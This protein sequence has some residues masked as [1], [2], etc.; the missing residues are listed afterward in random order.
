MNAL[1]ARLAR[2]YPKSN[3]DWGAKLV[4]LHEQMVGNI[5]P[6]LL[7]LLGA[8]GFVL[9]MA[10]ANIANLLLARAGAREKEIAIRLALGARR[11]RLIRQFLT[12]SILLSVLGGSAGMLLAVLGGELLVAI[13][14]VSIPR[15]SEMGPDLRL[16]GFTLAVVFLTGIIFGLIPALQA[17][18][19]DLNKVLKE[20]GR[21]SRASASGDRIRSVLVVSEI[22]IALVLLVGAGLLLKT[23]IRLQ[24]VNPGFN[25]TN[26]L[27]FNLQLPST[28]Y[29]DWLQ[30]SSFYSQLLERIK[31]LPGVQSADVA[32]FLPLESGWRM[33]FTITGQPK[34]ADGEDLMA[35]YRMVSPTYFQTMG[36]PLLQGRELTE[37]EDADAPGVVVINQAM[38]ARYWPGEDP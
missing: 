10:C 3:T 8:V 28:K 18:K 5:K 36:I 16:L 13:N 17:S 34:A 21:D 30:V 20:G 22:A 2:E 9:L 31:A 19:P 37:R 24:G 14:P 23:F 25:S 33:A 26:V 38:A 1:A 4:P 15:L 6:A 7:V 27:T 32:G 35:Q 12:E 29:G 11:A